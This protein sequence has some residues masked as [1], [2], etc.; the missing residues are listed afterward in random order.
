MIRR[1]ISQVEISLI[2]LKY[3]KG[4]FREMIGNRLIGVAYKKDLVY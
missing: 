2:L 4:F 1:I 3:V